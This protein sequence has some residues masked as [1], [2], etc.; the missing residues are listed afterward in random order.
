MTHANETGFLYLAEV[1]MGNPLQCTSA[2]H[3][4]KAACKQQQ[5]DS[6]FG[7]G[8]MELES[9]QQLANGTLVRYG[10]FATNTQLDTS[11]MFND[12]AVFNPGQVRIAYM[13]QFKRV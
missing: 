6:V 11:F 8:K 13:V 1:A 12:F 2:N 9:V 10:N 4:A 5:K 3:N 7:I